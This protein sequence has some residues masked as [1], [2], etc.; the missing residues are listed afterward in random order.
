MH[1]DVVEFEDIILKQHLVNIPPAGRVTFATACAQRVAPL[2]VR[3]Y[4][5]SGKGRPKFLEETLERLW[6]YL[7]GREFSTADRKKSIKKLESLVPDEDA[8]TD[9]G[10]AENALL[11]TTDALECSL[12]GDEEFAEMTASCVFEVIYYYVLYRDNIDYSLPNSTRL[13]YSDPMAQT[14]LVRQQRDLDEIAAACQQPGGLI[15]LIPTLRARAIAEA[16]MF[17]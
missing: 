5:L 14:E 1:Q 6:A 2:Y 15:A 16:I 11:A 7:Q 17:E 13:I 4:R 10:H 12:T 9:G 3:F 8:G